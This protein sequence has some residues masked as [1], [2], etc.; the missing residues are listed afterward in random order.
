MFKCVTALHSIPL[1]TAHRHWINTAFTNADSILN[2]RI[3]LTHFSMKVTNT[4]KVGI[5]STSSLC[6]LDA[7]PLLTSQYLPNQKSPY[8]PPSLLLSRSNRFCLVPLP[9]ETV[10]RRILLQCKGIKHNLQASTVHFRAQHHSCSSEHIPLGELDT[11]LSATIPFHR[12]ESHTH[13]LTSAPCFTASQALNL[14]CS[15]LQTPHKE[16]L[17]Q[18]AANPTS[19]IQNTVC[20]RQSTFLCVS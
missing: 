19:A 12:K 14:H 8:K 16:L 15:S 13:T 1:T 18:M 20:W 6:S 4:S 9:T 3:K 7:F 10:T 11:M 2:T 17:L 5:H